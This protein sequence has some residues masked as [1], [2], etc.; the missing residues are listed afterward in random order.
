[1]SIKEYVSNYDYFIK[2]KESNWYKAL[3]YCFKVTTKD[4]ESF[5]FYL[6]INP[7]N[8]VITTHFATNIIATAYGTVEEHSEQRYFDI[9]IS[10]TTGLAPKNIGIIHDTNSLFLSSLLKVATTSVPFLKMSNIPDGQPG[11]LSETLF[12]VNTGGFFNRTKQLALNAAKKA[13]SVLPFGSSEYDSG[14][15]DKHSG[16]VAFHNFY[17]FLVAY[18]KEILNSDGKYKIGEHPIQFINY[19]D[20]NQYNVAINNFQLNRSA[21]D[22]MLYKYT[23]AMR[24]YDLRTIGIEKKFEIDRQKELGLDGVDSQSMKAKLSNGVRNAKMALASAVAAIKGF[25]L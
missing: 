12:Q 18:K 16:Y 5:S 4:G 25:G 2:D 21:D 1:M 24:G 9:I 19:K 8:I 11:R 6:P 13:M 7:M 17:R 14:V 22:P 23:I 3:P 20:N 15:L 10:G